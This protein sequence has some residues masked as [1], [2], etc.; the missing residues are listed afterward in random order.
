MSKLTKAA[1]D[2]ACQIRVPG[3]CCGNP[4][5]VVGCHVRMIGISGFGLKAPDV[6][7]AWGC[8]SCHDV[9]DGRTKTEFSY[10]ERRLLLLEG[11]LRT[12]NILWR[13]GLIRA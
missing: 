6:F 13:E 3:Y 10:D 1:R 8:Q 5:T 7:I 11:M 9:V 2:R 12:Q 4:E